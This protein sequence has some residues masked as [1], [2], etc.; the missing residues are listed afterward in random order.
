MSSEIAPP[1]NDKDKQIISDIFLYEIDGRPARTNDRISKKDFWDVLYGPRAD[2]DFFEAFLD[3]GCDILCVSG[4]VGTGKSTYIRHK[5]EYL[6][7]TCGIIIDCKQHRAKILVA[8]EAR[9]ALLKAIEDVIRES[10][11]EFA[12]NHIKISAPSFSYMTHQLP[13]QTPPQQPPSHLEQAAAIGLE[14]KAKLH[15]ASLILSMTDL[16][17]LTIFRRSLDFLATATS[18]SDPGQATE[19]RFTLCTQHL[20]EINCD[21][22]FSLMS[23]NDWITTLRTTTNAQKGIVIC[24]DNV[25]ALDLNSVG[26]HLIDIIIMICNAINLD[27][28]IAGGAVKFVFSIREENILRINSFEDFS[29]RI[30][31]V[32]LGIPWTTLDA[33]SRRVMDNDDIFMA[34]VTKKRITALRALTKDADTLDAIEQTMFAYWFGPVSGDNNT[35][36][37]MPELSRLDIVKFSNGSVRRALF[38]IQKSCLNLYAIFGKTITKFD[39]MHRGYVNAVMKGSV[40]RTLG[41]E[42]D[43]KNIYNRLMLGLD[44]EISSGTCCLFRL[45]LSY[46]YNSGTVRYRNIE[47][48][49]HCYF[50]Y[51]IESIREACFSLYRSPRHRGELIVISQ[52]KHI[53]TPEDIASD[54][55]LSI[56]ERGG[57]LLDLLIINV[58]YFSSLAG[59]S[60]KSPPFLSMSIVDAIEYIKKIYSK[61]SV[62]P[63]RYDK[64]LEDAAYKNMREDGIEDPREYFIKNYCVGNAFYSNR[65]MNSHM[66]SIHRYAAEYLRGDESALVKYYGRQSCSTNHVATTYPRTRD[67]LKRLVIRANDAHLTELYSY[68][69]K[70][71]HLL[72]RGDH[73]SGDSRK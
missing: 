52:E 5:L 3:G 69:D 59:K 20:T 16:A 19:A 15:L 49:L 13:P 10:L 9:E 60:K 33:Q 28:R 42:L 51:T 61:V 35:H 1:I 62:L 50:G 23:W 63:E 37:L 46:L 66:S 53:E 48:D 31:S 71:L 8:T 43:D 40:L 41:D 36:V 34:T 29:Q 39:E 68:Y 25:D 38:T 27:Q 58:D 26:G 73:L 57:H 67:E 24:I 17:S 32:V 14:R 56:S 45:T 64:Y 12:K 22:M 47:T 72:S 70:Y 54:A 30:S 21:E 7:D 18:I 11:I 44:K 2:D 4:R 55:E 6:H 65:F